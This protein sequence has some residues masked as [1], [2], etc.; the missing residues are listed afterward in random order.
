MSAPQ[1]IE[2]RIRADGQVYFTALPEEL[3]EIAATL[4][5]N[6]A[7]LARR[8]ALL[9]EVRSRAPEAGASESAKVGDPAEEPKHG[10]VPSGE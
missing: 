3:L 5:P 8:L 2:I 4:S 10:V 1:E 6:D 9:R 7:S